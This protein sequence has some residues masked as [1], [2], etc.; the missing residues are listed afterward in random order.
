MRQPAR[1][2]AVYRE[3]IAKVMEVYG[4]DENCH[5]LTPPLDTLVPTLSGKQLGNEVGVRA[6][7]RGDWEAID[8]IVGSMRPGGAAWNALDD[9]ARDFKLDAATTGDIRGYLIHASEF[10]INQPA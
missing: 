9:V 4:S 10:M 8:R 5:P 3:L 2:A 7:D 6:A 1:A